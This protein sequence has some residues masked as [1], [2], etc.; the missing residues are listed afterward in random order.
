MGLLPHRLVLHD[1]LH[2]PLMLSSGLTRLFVLFGLLR[3]RSI[4]QYLIYLMHEISDL[5]L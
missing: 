5:I 1:L 2:T 4:P 3:H